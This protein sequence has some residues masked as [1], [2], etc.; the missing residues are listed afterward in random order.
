MNE[1]TEN[2]GNQETQAV[3][4][5]NSI[6]MIPVD[7]IV[8]N[9]ANPRLDV[10]DV[11]ELAESI[12]AQGIRQN[13]LVTPTGDGR[14]ML[15]IGHRRLAAA[16]Q[17]GLDSVPC[18]V[19]A[20]SEREQR[21]IMLVENSQRRDLTLLEEANG[22]QGLLDLGETQLGVAKR[23]G[24]SVDYVRA[25]ARVAKTAE[26]ASVAPSDASYAQISLD[27]WAKMSE[28]EDDPAALKEILAHA[29][30]PNF[31]WAI[32]HASNR[33]KTDANHQ[34]LARRIA[35]MNIPLV[36][37]RPKE[38]FAQSQWFDMEQ[39]DAMSRIDE[40]LA[41]APTP[42]RLKKDSGDYV[43]FYAGAKPK[44]QS[45]KEREIQARQEEEK[46]KRAVRDGFALRARQN[47]L[48]FLI[49]YC[50]NL[51][52][53]SQENVSFQLELLGV[54][55]VAELEHK[56]SPCAT[57][58]GDVGEISDADLTLLCQLK[59]WD[60]GKARAEFDG[61]DHARKR[62]LALLVIFEDTVGEKGSYWAFRSNLKAVGR[63]Y[64]QALERI[65]YQVSDHEREAL[66]GAYTDKEETK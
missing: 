65:G 20:L 33:R 4:Q 57:W 56:G 64:Y 21:E 30:T 15:V 27:E 61:L 14:Y 53:L 39:D 13:L 25:R 43:V 46:R 28:F 63:P 9:P 36:D 37:D 12:K 11:S 6:R 52:P 35:D 32:T 40:W 26:A 48:R 10:G 7:A 8:P 34:A 58:T 59:G 44:K 29:G 3:G 22:V 24:R 18:A 23:T 38:G 2:S 55:A 51:K 45:E 1:N 42:I 16:K 66:D 62:L 54:W 47:R 41:K 19:A 50:R 17:A 31:D 49:D 5:G 60:E